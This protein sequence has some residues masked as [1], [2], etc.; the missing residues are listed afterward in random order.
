M[1][2]QELKETF[3]DAEMMKLRRFSKNKQL[4]QHN[5]DFLKRLKRRDFLK[6]NSN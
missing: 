4:K 3:L 2:N 5:E 1:L 6:T